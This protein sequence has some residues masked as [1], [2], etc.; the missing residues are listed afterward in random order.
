[1]GTGPFTTGEVP[2][3]HELSGRDLVDDPRFLIRDRL[4]LAGPERRSALRSTSFSH[5]S[6]RYHVYPFTTYGD[7]R[8]DVELRV[9]DPR[10]AERSA[11][12][13]LGPRRADGSWATVHSSVGEEA[14]VSIHAT[15]LAE[16]VAVVGPATPAGFLP[17]YPGSEAVLE[18]E[19]DEGY[20]EELASIEMN[21]DAHVVL[22]FAGERD[23]GFDGLAGRRFRV[24]SP[25][26]LAADVG[27]LGTRP[28]DL[29]F[30]EECADPDCEQTDGE[31]R[32]F[33][34]RAWTRYQLF[35]P[36]HARSLDDTRLAAVN[37]PQEGDFT[38]FTATSPH[39]PEQSF[40]ILEAI[41]ADGRPNFE[42]PMLLRVVP[43]AFGECEV[44]I[45]ED[46]RCDE[47]MSSCRMPTCLGESGPAEE[48]LPIL[49]Y[50]ATALDIDETSL[51]DIEARCHGTCSPT[52]APTRYP[53]YLAHGFNSSKEVWDD[54]S[55][56]VI[57]AD[58]RWNG[59][60]AAE[61]VPAFEPVWRRAKQLRRNLASYLRSLEI[62]GTR[63]AEGEPFQRVNVIAHSMGGLDSRVLTGDPIYNNDQCHEL[64]ECTDERGEPEPCCSADAE[65]HAIPWRARIA[66]VTTL[67]T[68]HRGS[69][70][71]DVGVSLLE[72]RSVDWAFRKTA[73]YILGLD[74]E[75]EQQHLR[76]TLFTL[77]N[78]FSAETMTPAFPA[79]QP[80]RIYTYACAAGLEECEVPEG[81]DLPPDSG[82][83][84]PPNESVTFFGWA[85]ES[86][87]T[88][89][90]GSIV[91]P[92]LALSYGIVKQREGPGDGVVATSSA[93]FGIYM[94]VRANDHFHWNRLSFA[95]VVDLAA[96]TFGVR[97]EPVDRFYRHWLGAL[98]RSGY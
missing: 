45:V 56:R 64:R 62:L 43:L 75:E 94:G 74:T 27:A 6:Q 11:L 67:S 82:T 68:P 31:M 72:K 16:Y 2:L 26:T 98:A 46:P 65:G 78:Q 79:P 20:D 51:Y 49:T 39:R 15:G 28:F 18:I 21:S 22:A 76:D 60:L 66:S 29:V 10:M 17:R 83:L 70:F 32:T 24:V 85:S 92:G 91:D 23:P 81:A 63:P 14:E 35:A 87:I 77:S 8:V 71:A 40:R 54:V 47:P 7:S 95:K 69:S 19:S 96:R 86:C 90:C 59:W 89:A 57:A 12:W 30:A 34:P 25:A 52:A 13:I 53:V 36:E 61:S 73:R 48:D 93:Q 5:R 55:Q 50:R 41:G 88:G 4:D 1:M 3:P 44:D 58:E 9:H 33:A 84:P 42:D 97:R 37:E 80:R 38:V